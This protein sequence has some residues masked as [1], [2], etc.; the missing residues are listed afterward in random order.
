M[1]NSDAIERNDKMGGL[2]MSS[3]KLARKFAEIVK[4]RKLLQNRQFF[5]VLITLPFQT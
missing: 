3:L 5:R 4:P 2:K 1:N